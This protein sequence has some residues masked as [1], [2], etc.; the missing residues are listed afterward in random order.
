MRK[1]F[2]LSAKRIACLAF[3]V[4]MGYCGFTADAQRSP[5]AG[6]TFRAF[7]EIVEVNLGGTV[8]KNPSFNPNIVIP[9]DSEGS[10]QEVTLNRPKPYFVYNPTMIEYDEDGLEQSF[11]PYYIEP[12]ITADGNLAFDYWTIDGE[13]GF[14]DILYQSGE[15]TLYI[16]HH[17]FLWDNDPWPYQPFYEV[18]FNVG[19]TPGA[20][21]STPRAGATY[22]NFSI[23]TINLAWDNIWVKPCD[24]YGYDYSNWTAVAQDIK[25]IKGNSSDILQGVGQ[26]IAFTLTPNYRQGSTSWAGSFDIVPAQPLNDPS[27]WYVLEIPQGTLLFQDRDTEDEGY[28][29]DRLQLIYT[30]VGDNGMI[31]TPSQYQP[32]TINSFEGLRLTSKSDKINVTDASLIGLYS[33]YYDQ[34]DNRIA[35]ATPIATGTLY[36]GST[37]TDVLVTFNFDKTKMYDG[38]YTIWAQPGSIQGGLKIDGKESTQEGDIRFTITGNPMPIEALNVGA[39]PA[40]GSQVDAI[41]EVRVWWGNKTVLNQLK[42]TISGAITHNGVSS[43]ISWQIKTEQRELE[44]VDPDDNGQV[45]GIAGEADYYLVYNPEP[46]VTA[47]GEYVITVDPGTVGVY[48]KNDNIPANLGVSLT[49]VVAGDIDDDTYM[50]PASFSMSGG[51][52]W[53][54][55]TSIG[56]L[57]LTWGRQPITFADSSLKPT[58]TVTPVNPSLATETYELTAKLNKMEESSGNTPGFQE[59]VGNEHDGNGDDPSASLPYVGLNLDAPDMVLIRRTPGVYTYTIPAGIVK[60]AKGDLNPAQTISYNVIKITEIEPTL[61]P[62]IPRANPSYDPSNPGFNLDAYHQG[63]VDELK[64]VTISWDNKPIELIA[65]DKEDIRLHL[66]NDQVINL[67]EAGCVVVEDNKLILDISKYTTEPDTYEILV[68]AMSVQINEGG[69]T[70]FNQELVLTYGLNDTKAPNG[71]ISAPATVTDPEQDM[72]A[73]LFEVTVTWD[74]QAIELGEN[75][76]AQ[77]YINSDMAD[78]ENLGELLDDALEVSLTTLNV[79]DGGGIATM[80]ESDTDG[81]ELEVKDALVVFL[82]HESFGKKGWFNIVIPKATVKNLAGE[83]NDMVLV[84]LL[85]TDNYQGA[86]QVT[87]EVEL[88]GSANVQTLDYITVSFEDATGISVNEPATAR[89]NQDVISK[90]PYMSYVYNET[91]G[92]VTGVKFNVKPLVNETTKEYTLVIPEGT[93]IID[94]IYLNQEFYASYIVTGNGEDIINAIEAED[95]VYNVYTVGGV[96]VLSTANNADLDMLPAGFYIINGKKVLNK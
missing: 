17:Y 56:L 76:T 52:K 31:A 53:P 49:Y 89:I 8:A 20:V 82:P 13:T 46:P 25:L 27:L 90:Q 91:D 73:S 39:S 38:G 84:K 68:K 15:W 70:S 79:G 40:R 11:G 95:G 28:L 22:Q 33:G 36:A 96:R 75:N 43:P 14:Y 57:T 10:T 65:N 30:V 3:C 41:R 18:S 60:N 58:L 19:F 94:D 12:E 23:S 26:E 67:L 88:Y 29:T 5:Q 44:D 92:S 2:Y 80:E 35:D 1:N 6:K 48:I 47:P 34:N 21:I 61:T 85:V 62:F 50:N 66:S 51:E 55:I 45:G 59:N 54:D 37:D 78:Y 42:N 7:P 63:A 72:V 16:P 69:A 74:E 71:F 77:L 24:E 83:V 9:P 81:E 4:A 87:P 64:T 93:F 32:M 86:I